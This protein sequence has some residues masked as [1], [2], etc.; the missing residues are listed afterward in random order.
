MKQAYIT[1]QAVSYTHLVFQDAGIDSRTY[2]IDPYLKNVRIDNP[3]PAVAHKE[4]LQLI[5]NA[6]RC[7]LYQDR[8]QKIFLKSSFLP[9]MAASSENETYFSN[10]SSVLDG[11]EKDNYALT[12]QKHSTRCV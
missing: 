11:S 6:G 10:V 12:G 5:A 7:I 1:I 2:W 8:S 3:M 9:D 4:A